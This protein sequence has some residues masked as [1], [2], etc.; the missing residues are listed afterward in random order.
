MAILKFSK[1]HDIV[2]TINIFILSIISLILIFATTYNATTLESGAGTFKKQILFFIIGFFIYFFISSI[3]ITYLKQPKILFLLFSITLF[4]LIYVK[5]FSVEIAGTKRWIKILG[6]N[7]QPAEYAKITLIILSSAILTHKEFDFAHF[8]KF[9]SQINKIT[10]TYKIKRFLSFLDQKYPKL[11]KIFLTLIISA[12]IILLVFIQPA[13]GNSVIM[14]FLIFTIIFASL[15]EQLKLINFLIPIIII[16]LSYWNLLP[17]LN[18]INDLNINLKFLNINI[19]LLIFTLLITSLF[20]LKSKL[21]LYFVIISI[22][23]AQF[24]RPS[25][26]FIWNTNI[27]DEYQKQR[28][29][30]YFKSPENDPLNAGYQVRQSK[31]AI[32]AGRLFGRGFLKGTQST[33]QVLP[34]AHTDFIFA[35]LAE[36]FGLVGASILFS[37]YIII[38]IRLLNTASSLNDIFGVLIISGVIIM[39]LLNIFINIGMNLGKLPVTGVPLPL[40]SY[41]GSSVLVNMIGLGLTQAIRANIK[42]KD[43]AE[44]FTIWK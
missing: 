2:I 19:T 24:I 31:I 16:P 15:D 44:S 12:P 9:N 3:N 21:P 6:F 23:I 40:I 17:F 18:W 43:I 4:L 5:L 13:F 25:I 35:S 32:G 10:I 14:T 22:I 37:L 1:N 27:L 33:L 30:T 8:I 36:Q 41:G 39:M 28:I 7:I 11:K 20:S 34:F 38:F 26:L 42:P 29:E